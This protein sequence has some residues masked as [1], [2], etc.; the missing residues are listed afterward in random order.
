M[1]LAYFETSRDVG[2]SLPAPEAG[3]IPAANRRYAICMTFHSRLGA[4]GTLASF[5]PLGA[6]VMVSVIPGANSEFDAAKGSAIVTIYLVGQHGAIFT[7]FP[8]MLSGCVL[9]AVFLVWAD[10]L[11]RSDGGDG[12]GA[13]GDCGDRGD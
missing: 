3:Y 7:G 9:S 12:S 11:R 1:F 6:I 13:V 4:I 5:L 2:Q 10:Y 8:C